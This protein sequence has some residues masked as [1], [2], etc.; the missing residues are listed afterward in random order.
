LQ[1]TQ[2]YLI[3]AQNSD[4][5]RPSGGYISTWGWMRVRSGDIQEYEYFPTTAQNPSPPPGSL[6]SLLEI[7]DWWFQFER[8]IY[9]AWDGSWHADFPATA[10]MASWF[11]TNGE[12]PY[13]PVDGVIGI[14]LVA[15]EYIV[16]ALIQVKVPGYNVTVNAENFREMVYEIRA[17]DDPQLNHKEFVAAMY[18]QILEDWQNAPPRIRSNVNRAILQALREKHIMLY[19]G[20]SSLQNSMYRLGWAG[21]QTPGVGYDYLMVADA[22]IGSKSSR[23]VQRQMTY[24]VTIN[25]DNTVNNRLSVLYNFSSTVAEQDPA[26][27]PEHYREL[28]YFSLSQYFVPAGSAFVSSNN[29]FQI[30]EESTDEHTIYV[31][32]VNVPY[33]Q[34]TRVQ[35]EYSTPN[36]TDTVGSYSR[37][38]L[39]LEKQPGTIADSGVVTVSLPPG[40]S[41]VAV[42]P[43][44]SVVYELGQPVLEFRFTLRTDMWIEIIYE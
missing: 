31:G 1:Q 5:I 36:I 6:A 41:V 17:S 35:L 20:E 19:F 12:N 8:P 18:R 27:R 38:R 39:Y 29:L 43:Q 42:D 22:N 10:E 23:S 24:D 13:A 7:P 26:V 37:Y 11:Y 25:E 32:Y 9:T 33:D 34:T 28:D 44:P 21:E 14:D 40:S 3:L 30:Q 15:T 4:E 16:D 2:T